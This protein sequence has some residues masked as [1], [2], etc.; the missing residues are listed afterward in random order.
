MLT[1]EVH[2]ACTI[3]EI[4]MR[5]PVR[6][7]FSSS[8]VDQPC[9]D[10]QSTC[11]QGR[12][13]SAVPHSL[14]VVDSSCSHNW[15][16]CFHQMGQS[17]RM[18]WTVCSASLQSQ[19]AESMMPVRLRCAHRP[20]CPVRNLHIVVCSCHARRLIGSVQWLNGHMRKSLTNM[21]TPSVLP[22]K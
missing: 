16:L 3:P 20:K 2:S 1:T 6:W 12:R 18:W 5:L 7:L 19:S 11:C 21:G 14:L 9:L 22:Q 8:A 15:C 4:R 17:W 13:S 10:P